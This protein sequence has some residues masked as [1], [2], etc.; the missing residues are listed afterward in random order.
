MPKGECI[1]Y[2]KYDSNFYILPPCVLQCIAVL[3]CITMV[4]DTY[5]SVM[6]SLGP[7]VFSYPVYGSVLF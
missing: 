1:L 3:P 2:T 5:F 6:W 4:T 7:C